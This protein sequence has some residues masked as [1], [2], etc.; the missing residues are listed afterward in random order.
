ML[1]PEF[2]PPAASASFAQ[3]VERIALPLNGGGAGGF[4]S[5]MSEVRAEVN[6]F[7]ANGSGSVGSIHLSPEGNA[8]RNRLQDS[9]VGADRTQ[10]QDFLDSVA[11]WAR[12]TADRLGIAPELVAAHAALE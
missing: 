8:Y 5:L 9:G 3:E 10:Q 4:A 7:I 2:A 12:E 6:D 11:P 1:R